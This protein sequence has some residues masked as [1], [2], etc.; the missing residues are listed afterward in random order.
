VLRD[1]IWTALRDQG[2]NSPRPHGNFIWLETKHL[3]ERAT[4]IFSEHGIVAR[5][6]GSDGIRISIGE[7][8]SVESLLKASEEV[9][10][11]LP[12]TL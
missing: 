7:R 4:E 9:V 8:E 11:S 5:A 3:T 1:E 12:S 10:R 2:W 6:L